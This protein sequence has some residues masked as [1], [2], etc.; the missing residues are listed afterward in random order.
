ML[1]RVLRRA[2]RID[3]VPV[4]R[5][6]IVASCSRATAGIRIGGI[7]AARADARVASR[8]PAVRNRPWKAIRHGRDRR[9]LLG[10][11]KTASTT[12][13]W[14]AAMMRALCV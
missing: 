6:E 11:A 2:G 1:E 4:E 10:R 13:E 5:A 8:G 12:T 7:A 9:A 3:R 14:P